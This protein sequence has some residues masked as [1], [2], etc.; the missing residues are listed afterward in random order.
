[1]W[2]CV[3][4][5]FTRGVSCDTLCLSR[6]PPCAHKVRG[7]TSAAVGPHTALRR[8]TVA[9]IGSMDLCLLLIAAWHCLAR[10]AF[11]ANLCPASQEI[12]YQTKTWLK[13]ANETTVNRV[14]A[15]WLLDYP[16]AKWSLCTD[17]LT[18]EQAVWLVRIMPDRM[19]H[20]SL[21]GRVSCRSMDWSEMIH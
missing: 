16:P 12:V 20:F 19:T 7:L 18:V 4:C 14:R 6:S 10:P 11:E 3:S 9:D 13:A 15:L 17:W 8:W 5:M 2:T 1:M 21:I